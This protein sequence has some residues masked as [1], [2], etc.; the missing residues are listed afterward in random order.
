MESTTFTYVSREIIDGQLSVAQK[1]MRDRR[2]DLAAKVLNDIVRSIRNAYIV[3]CD[4]TVLDNVLEEV[5][6][7][8]LDIAF[9]RHHDAFFRIKEVQ[10]L[11]VA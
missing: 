9:K 2:Y 3:R 4:K 5:Y 8:L 7:T 10:T 11:L 6:R 1:L